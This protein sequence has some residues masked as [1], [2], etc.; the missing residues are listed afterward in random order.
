MRDWTWKDFEHRGLNVIRWFGGELE[1]IKRRWEGWW[2]CVLYDRP[3][4][5]ITATKS[6]EVG[7]VETDGVGADFLMRCAAGVTGE[8]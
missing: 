2:G 4:I 3:L 7:S 5:C 6:G 1:A 8:G